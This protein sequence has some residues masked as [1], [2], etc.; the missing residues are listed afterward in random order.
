MLKKTTQRDIQS[1][2][3]LPLL[4]FYWCEYALQRSRMH[5]L[6]NVVRVV[7]SSHGFEEV[8]VFLETIHADKVITA[9][10]SPVKHRC[11]FHF[12]T[13]NTNP[14]CYKLNLAFRI[15]ISYKQNQKRITTITKTIIVQ[16]IGQF[17]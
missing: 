3:H 13:K 10:N 7:T 9:Q 16:G 15:H 1:S 17:G 5:F 2:W 6:E 14:L 12:K 8:L 4:P 11:T